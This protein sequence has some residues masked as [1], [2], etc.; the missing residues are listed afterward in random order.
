MQ[1]ATGW[2]QMTDG[3]LG[4][5]HGVEVYVRRD[6]ERAWLSVRGPGIGPDRA[7][8]EYEIPVSQADA[9]HHCGLA[10]PP[11]VQGRH[12][13]LHAGQFWMV[14]A[15]QGRLAGI[16]VAEI[17]MRQGSGDL[18]LPP[19]IGREVTDDARFSRSGL[20]SLAWQSV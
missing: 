6:S 9:L 3:I 18:D 2:R 15:Y 4:K 11:L 19:W 8:F 1:G 10:G 17:K 20:Q 5:L 12:V 7:E 14:D 13:V 16:V